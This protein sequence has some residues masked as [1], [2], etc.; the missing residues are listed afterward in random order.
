[1]NEKTRKFIP[2]N[3]KDV[4]PGDEDDTLIV[5]VSYFVA[6]GEFKKLDVDFP[7]K[8]GRIQKCGK[9]LQSRNDCA[10][11]WKNLIIFI[12]YL[13]SFRLFIPL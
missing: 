13:Y 11:D 10:E 7:D 4:K 3:V 5:S 6:N 2:A 12:S 8:R 1:M 9:I